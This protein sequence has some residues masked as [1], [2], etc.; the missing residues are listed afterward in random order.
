MTRPAP[1]FRL[2]V[3]LR[4]AVVLVGAGWMT[5]CTAA[6]ARTVDER[7][8]SNHWV[9]PESSQAVFVTRVSDEITIAWMSLANMRYTIVARDPTRKDAP[10]TPVKGYV[11]MA[12]TGEQA[13]VTLRVPPDD[14]RVFNLRAVPR[15][16]VRPRR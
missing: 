9:L 2:A 14:P 15:R 12:G 1:N 13:Q 7:A 3:L 4:C 8:P 16:P 11:D 5:A 6:S 10:W